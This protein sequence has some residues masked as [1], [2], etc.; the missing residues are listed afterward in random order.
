M[1][2]EIIKTTPLLR[3]YVY[4]GKDHYEKFRD[5]D[6]GKLDD[7]SVVAY[8]MCNTT[9]HWTMKSLEQKKKG[10]FILLTHK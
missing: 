9:A 10:N 1:S 2:Q 7:A 6:W 4:I 5:M 8:F 3:G